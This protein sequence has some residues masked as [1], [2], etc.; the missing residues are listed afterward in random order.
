M[1]MKIA[2][3]LVGLIAIPVPNPAVPPFFIITGFRLRLPPILFTQAIAYLLPF[4]IV[5][6]GF[7]ASCIAAINSAGTCLPFTSVWPR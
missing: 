4:G 7:C 2:A 1:A 3:S 5:K 6:I